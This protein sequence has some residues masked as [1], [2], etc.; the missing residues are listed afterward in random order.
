MGSFNPSFIGGINSSN[1]N[2]NRSGGGGIKRR[3][4]NKKYTEGGSEIGNK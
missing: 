4:L 1:V 3:A 2:S